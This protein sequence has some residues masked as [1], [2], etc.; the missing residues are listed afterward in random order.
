MYTKR[1]ATVLKATL[2]L[3]ENTHK[4]TMKATNAIPVKIPTTA[5]ERTATTIA[6]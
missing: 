5:V 4:R 1:V 3:L 6:G 2:H